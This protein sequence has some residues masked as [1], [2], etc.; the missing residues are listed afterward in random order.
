M[1]SFGPGNTPP[2]PPRHAN[3]S[4]ETK[5][6]KERDA[7]NESICRSG[8]PE[9]SVCVVFRPCASELIPSSLPPVHVFPE[10]LALFSSY[11]PSGIMCRLRRIG[12]RIHFLLRTLGPF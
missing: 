2:P 6:T 1:P 3:Y 5:G 8:W 11:R 12:S 9:G 7:R 10:L 4:D